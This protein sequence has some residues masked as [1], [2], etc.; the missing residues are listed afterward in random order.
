MAYHLEKVDPFVYNLCD[1][2][3]I[4]GWMIGEGERWVGKVIGAEK[5]TRI[6]E[7]RDEL[8]DALIEDLSCPHP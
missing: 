2:E 8:T 7:T 1:E 6:Y 3:K 4:V 5:A